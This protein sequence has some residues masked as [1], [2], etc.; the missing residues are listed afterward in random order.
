MSKLFNI[1]CD[2]S[3]HLENVSITADNRYMVLGGILCEASQ[4]EE[5]FDR[6]KDIKKEHD[7]THASEMK[8][9]KVSNGKLQAYKDIVNYFF[10]S[11]LSFRAVIIDKAQ[12][13]HEDFNHTHDAF[14]YKMYW[15]M[16]EWFMEPSCAY[17]IYLDIKDTKGVAKVARL[18]EVLCNSTHDFDREIVLKMQEVR[19]HEI[20][21]MQVVDILI[22][23]VSYAS[24]YPEGGVSKAKN[25]IVSLIRHRTG[26]TLTSSTLLGASKFNL[27]HW[28]GRR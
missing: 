15:Q 24:R 4:K 20:A 25:E 11:Q 5:I 9:T 3:C 7:M 8:W 28:E 18:H 17:N 10:D 19:S 1:Y 22:G 12:L 13:R 27:F 16:L 2:E 21:L 14:Y 6:L 23:A 26:L